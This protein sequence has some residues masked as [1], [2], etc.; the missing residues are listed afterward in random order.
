QLP[1]LLRGVFYEGWNPSKVPVKYSKDEYIARFAKDAQIHHAEVPR[2]GRL[3]RMRARTVPRTAAWP[4]ASVRRR[5]PR[6]Q[7]RRTRAAAGQ[8]VRSDHRGGRRA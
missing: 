6:R 3:V 2:A 4:K 7:P 5:R 1:E 8:E